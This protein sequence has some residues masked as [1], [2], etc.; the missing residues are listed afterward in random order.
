MCEPHHTH[1][2]R[3]RFFQA[4]V[5]QKGPGPVLAPHGGRKKGT[6]ILSYSLAS[7]GRSPRAV[8]RPGAG[9]ATSVGT[10]PTHSTLPWRP[11]LFGQVT[12]TKCSTMLLHTPGPLL[13]Y[14]NKTKHT[15]EKSWGGGQ[16]WG[17]DS[18]P[19]TSLFV[20]SILRMAP[21][22]R[23]WVRTMTLSQTGSQT[24]R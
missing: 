20:A 24:Q 9:P 15:K 11:A 17:E 13:C 1:T 2:P 6:H 4:E 12:L 5:S 16:A 19:R 18:K 7:C 14:E 23:S 8:C 3:V 10:P 21:W 22:Q